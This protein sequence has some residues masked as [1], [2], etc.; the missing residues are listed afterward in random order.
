[1]SWSTD[2]SFTHFRNP[3]VET[4][5]RLLRVLKVRELSKR[6]IYSALEAFP[7]HMLEKA[8]RGDFW[9][10]MRRLRD[11]G[12]RPAR[13]VDVGAYD[14]AWARRVAAL[15]PEASFLLIE[16]ME[17]K[18]EILERVIHEIG[19]CLHLET[20][21]AEPGRAVAFYESETGSSIYKSE[22]H[23]VVVT[24]KITT[25]LD[26][27]LERAGWDGADLIKLDIQGAE[28]EALSGGARALRTAQVVIL[29]L[30]FDNFYERSPLVSDAISFMRSHGFFLRDV[31]DVKRLRRGDPVHQLDG[32]FVKDPALLD[33]R[34]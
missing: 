33:R 27:I 15:F 8:T 7:D 3:G 13:I 5:N 28:L 18:R 22:I 2:N 29:E 10:R 30:S 17:G 21:S 20:L 14:G 24:Q 6:M 23:P 32:F 25:T 1:M 11:S 9:S 19:G 31:A 26:D 12:F 34:R 4:L 16:A